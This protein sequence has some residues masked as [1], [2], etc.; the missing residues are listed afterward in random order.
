MGEVYEAEDQQLRERVAVRL[1]AT[2]RLT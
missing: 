2:L 1:P